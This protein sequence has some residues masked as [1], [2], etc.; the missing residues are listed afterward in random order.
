MT[1]FTSQIDAWYNAIQYR[2]PPASELAQFNAQLQAGIITTAQAVSQIEA[3]SY[4]QN[5]VDPVIREYQAAFGRVP[6]QAGVAYWVGQVAANPANL[7]VLSTIFAN[8][9]EF[10]LTYGASATTPASSTLVAALYTNVLGRTPDAAGLAYWSS[11]NLNAAQLLQAFAQSGEF[12]AD[13]N[14]Y[15]VQFQNSEVAGTEPTTGSLYIQAIPGG[16]AAN[17][18]TI[19]YGAPTSFSITGGLNGQPLT[20]TIS[21]GPTGPIA[22]T[23]AAQ[24]SNVT[25]NA[26]LGLNNFQSIV[27]TGINNVLN[28]NYA[29]GGS[30]TDS[31]FPGSNFKQSGLNIQGVQTWNIQGSAG[32][33]AGNSYYAHG[34]TI[35]FTG[36]AA[37]GNVISG[38]RTVNFNDNSG[39]DTLL[40][41]DNSEPVQE[42]NGA[43]GFAINV[44][45][46]VGTGYNGVDVDIAAQAFTGKDTINVG[47][48]I[49][50]GFPQ[51]NG[52]Y[53]IP[54]LQTGADSNDSDTYNPNWL[55][56]EQNAFAIAAGASAGPNGPVGFAN[57]VVTSAGAQSVGTVNILA[58]GGEGSSSAQTLTVVNPANDSSATILFS[59]A[60]S[61]SLSTDW[62]NLNS[63]TLTG[64]T[65][66]VVLTGAEVDVAQ[67]SDSFATQGQNQSHFFGGGL[68][69]SDTTALKTIAGGAGNSFYDLSSLT[70]AGIQAFNGAESY[71][72]GHGTKANS[73]IAFNNGV[74]ANATATPGSGTVIN[75]SHIQ[76]LDDVSDTQ[77]GFIDLGVDFAGLAPLNTNYDL[78]SGALGNLFYNKSGSLLQDPTFA[79]S[80]DVAPAGYQLIQFLNAEGSTATTLG[81][82][83]TIRDGFVNLA[84]N[85]IDMADGTLTYINSDGPYVNPNSIAWSG[86]NITIEGQFAG[87]NVNTGDH[88]KLWVSD[89]GVSN[90]FNAN[91]YSQTGTALYVPDVTIANYTTVDIYLP[92]ESVGSKIDSY[93]TQDYVILGGAAPG[94]APGTYGFND[95]PVITANASVNFYDN[96]VDTG[97]SPPGGADD[98]VLG[99]T[100]FTG[101]LDTTLIGV[102]TVIV[103]A[104]TS[105]TGTTINDFGHG[106]LE[107]GAT[108]AAVL[109]AASTSHLIQDLPASTDWFALDAI[110]GAKGITV[111]GSST[112][113]N[114][115]QGGSGEV[116]FDTTNGHG[117]N[118]NV[119]TLANPSSSN[120][121]NDTL[122]GGADTLSG[123]VTNVVGNGGD[124]FFGEGGND[125][126]NVKSAGTSVGTDSTVWI[127]EYD[128]GNN[129]G[130]NFGVYGSA[131]GA[132]WGVGQTYGQAITDI[133]GGAEKYV[134]GYATST[135]N[136]T[137]FHLS[138]NGTTGDTINFNS[139]DWAVG[140][141]SAGTDKGLVDNHG[142]HIGAGAGPST[143]NL[144]TAPGI[145]SI[146]FTQADVTLDGIANYASAQYLVQALQQSN[147][148]NIVVGGLL[149]A[150]SEEHV[151]VAYNSG[152][153]VNI[154]DVTIQN[155]SGSTQGFLGLNTADTTHLKVSAIDLVDITGTATHN[156]VSLGNITAHNLFFV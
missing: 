133:V 20:G 64:T 84:I 16:I 61:D 86:Y 90:L 89:D 85:A 137:G 5:F 131:G 81:S 91:Y 6:D 129:G 88:L 11:Q 107:I 29:K 111:I 115:L 7:G 79:N 130:N 23:E 10:N 92:Y 26:A 83:L 48:Y 97:G 156:D 53:I 144:I 150:G 14:P 28:A 117:P 102:D 40:I 110:P 105:S 33:D 132:N 75:I 65:G 41:G 22:P 8:S 146:P 147:V 134:N 9:A 78:L 42:P 50:G 4:T 148:G 121:G 74:V 98:L 152:N 36:D 109:N 153:G 67:G 106:T 15:V 60:I 103:D 12:I 27:L 124:N 142:V 95:I 68:L 126:I 87:L 82:D 99:F 76:V 119:L 143:L 145:L 72:G 141:L 128:V 49:V 100:Q 35:S 56:F 80:T 104:F 46:A 38:L 125:T 52:S 39:I 112:G 55:G 120:I 96:T 45:N 127:G 70:L 43:N 51:Y 31:T 77:G 44:S 101:A 113:Q 37:V 47:A 3:S 17:T 118:D 32:A 139:L 71:D 30:E 151:L 122:T 25:I 21:G 2:N 154:A 63:I 18:Y 114:L 69:T 108:D 62:E 24:N 136:V 57:W 59:T 155:I 73:E 1:D 34:K 66:N 138:G 94:G 135:T 58:L 13:T 140:A 116:V 19:T 54:T 149:T 123:Y 93:N